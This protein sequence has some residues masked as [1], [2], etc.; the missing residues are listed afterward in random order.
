MDAGVCAV[1][2]L[3]SRTEDAEGVEWVH[4]WAQQATVLLRTS[5]FMLPPS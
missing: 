5:S 1:M 3:L 4:G 2:S